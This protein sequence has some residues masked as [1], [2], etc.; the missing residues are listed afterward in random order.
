MMIKNLLLDYVRYNLWVNTRLVD[1][2]THTDDA[3]VSH[4][5]TS[6]FP[7]IRHTL[8]HLWDV[9]SL[10]LSRLRGISPTTFPSE[11]FNGSN[12]EVYEKLLATSTEFVNFIESQSEN[13]FDETLSFTILS[14]KGTFHQKAVDMIHHCM[15]HQTFHRG[16]IITMARQLGMTQ[17]P[18]TDYI[19]FKRESEA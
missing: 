13:F 9:E 19:I 16:Q 8:I 2:F 4:E 3:I 6:S 7:S 5:I 17:F 12:E 1:L 11:T 15:N 14:A 10:W 18:R